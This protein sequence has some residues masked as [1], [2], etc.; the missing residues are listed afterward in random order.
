MSSYNDVIGKK[1]FHKDIYDGHEMIEIIG[2]KAVKE[3]GVINSYVLLEGDFSGGTHNV[4]QSA[5][6]P[7]EG[8]T[9]AKRV[10]T[11]KINGSC[12]HPNIYCNYPKCE[13]YV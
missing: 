3:N 2:M 9:L 13:E 10:C 7:A 11:E 5:W 12:P 6:L 1:A 8:V 4:K